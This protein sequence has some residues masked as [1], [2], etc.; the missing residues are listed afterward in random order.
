MKSYADKLKDPR[1]QKRRL[2]IMQRDKFH[3]R[4]C[5]DGT[6][7][8][9][10]HHLIYDKGKSPWDYPDDLLVTLCGAC[11]ASA[12]DR[13]LKILKAH[14]SLTLIHPKVLQQ[15]L[16]LIRD[17]F[18]AASGLAQT[19]PGGSEQAVYLAANVLL[20]ARDGALFVLHSDPM[21][22]MNAQDSDEHGNP[23]LDFL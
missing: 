16:V 11:H 10:V 20:E 13:T 19:N 17:Y 22:H 1:W 8:L 18:G 6:T 2:E 12:E 7:T 4:R 3:C 14:L 9:N 21:W 5:G 15:V 23:K